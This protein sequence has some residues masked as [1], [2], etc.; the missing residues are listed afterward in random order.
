[1][2]GEYTAVN[3]A[4]KVVPGLMPTPRAFGQFKDAE[5]PTYFYLSDF[6]DMDVINAPDPTLF[7]AAIAE[8]HQKS[9]SPNGMFGFYVTTCDGKNAH[10]V[11]WESNWGT[12]FGKLLRGVAKLDREANGPWKELDIAT[13]HTINHVIPRLL[14]PLQSNGRSIKPSLIHGDLWEGNVGTHRETG[15]I[16]LFDASSY[17]A[18]NEMDLGIWRAKWN[19]FRQNPYL[20][21]Y[22]R[23]FP[24]AEPVE[25]FDDRNRLY[26][27]KYNLNYSAG[28]PGAITRQ[29]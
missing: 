21:E 29:T 18:H 19:N 27:L 4:E 24:I 8:L 28:H 14:G 22:V 13:E 16:V 6:V 26:S 2:R 11:D 15:E 25:G 10:T 3:E 1:M 23:N 9:A 17:Y 20:R 7:C 12:F 5:T